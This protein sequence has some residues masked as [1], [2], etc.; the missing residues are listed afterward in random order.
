MHESENITEP[1]QLENV[2]QR[3]AGLRL[4]M[5]EVEE[6]TS[7]ALAGR[8]DEWRSKLLPCMD[9]LRDAWALHVSGTE[10]PGGLWEQ[11][12]TDAPR[13]DGE[14]RR[15]RREH[16]ARAADVAALRRDLADAGDDESRLDEVRERVTALLDRLARHRQRGADLIYEAYQRDVGGTG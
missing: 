9:N 7:A 13:L 3:R 5:T 10:G 14:L 4:T 16:E 15:L 12:R 11:I 1:V 6:A 2:R 8:P